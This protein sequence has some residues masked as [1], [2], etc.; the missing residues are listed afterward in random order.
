MNNVNEIVR[1]RLLRILHERTDI[2]KAVASAAERLYCEP[3]FFGYSCKTCPLGGS[4]VGGQHCEAVAAIQLYQ[5]LLQG[6]S[7]F[8]GF[9]TEC[10]IP[11]NPDEYEVKHKSHI[12]SVYGGM[13]IVIEDLFVCTCKECGEIVDVPFYAKLNQ[14]NFDLGYAAASQGDK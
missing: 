11:L 10:E 8:E 3:D 5:Y 9:C 4:I 1:N 2:E 6:V 13:N 12:K 14:I 7:P